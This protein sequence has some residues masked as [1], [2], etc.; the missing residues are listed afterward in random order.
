MLMCP[1]LIGHRSATRDN[2]WIIR[3]S[4]IIHSCRLIIMLILVILLIM[5]NKSNSKVIWVMKCYPQL[6]MMKNQTPS[7]QA[8]R[9]QASEMLSESTRK[10]RKIVKR[11]MDSDMRIH[12][13]SPISRIERIQKIWISKVKL[14]TFRCNQKFFSTTRITKWVDMKANRF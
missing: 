12:F 2:S 1:T 11:L 14:L 6:L 7:A 4:A 13:P 9:V 3:A 10:P 5:T 8:G